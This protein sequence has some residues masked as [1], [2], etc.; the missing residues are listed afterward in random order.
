[1]R[2]REALAEQLEGGA[3]S[4]ADASAE[5]ETLRQQLEAAKAE[6]QTLNTELE[7]LR[8]ALESQGAELETAKQAAADAAAAITEGADPEALSALQTEL[9]ELQA[10]RDATSAEGEQA[11][12]KRSEEL[13]RITAELAAEREA[14]AAREQSHAEELEA[15]RKQLG[16]TDAALTA[17]R[18]EMQGQTEAHQRQLAEAE[19]TGK[20]DIERMR[21]LYDG[22]AQLGGQLTEGGILLSL[23]GDELQFP[24]GSAELPERDL[25]TLDRVTELLKQWPDLSAR[26]EGH[27]DSLGSAEVN[28]SL[29]QQRAESVMQA[30]VRR[31][32]DAG[33]LSARGYGAERPIAS[34][35]TDAGRSENR[36]VEIYVIH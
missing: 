15:M 16:D 13:Q 27:T 17:L 26:V 19:A 22:A 8:A 7:R 28:Q 14:L 2:E 23:A 24:S 10:Q 4:A 33:R 5:S 18:A 29:S 32:I 35:A 31:G 34:N 36:R 1:M 25:P 3:A 9:A 12:A 30:L 11:L 6:T 21:A 20:Q